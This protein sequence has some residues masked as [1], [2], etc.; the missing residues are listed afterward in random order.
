MKSEFFTSGSV[1]KAYSSG[2]SGFIRDVMGKLYYFTESSF[3]SEISALREG[4]AVIFRQD[5]VENG[6]N[7]SKQLFAVDVSYE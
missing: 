5:R 4:D 1:E 3:A 7:G 6:K 2:K